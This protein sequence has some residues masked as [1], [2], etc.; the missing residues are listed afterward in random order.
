MSG[1]GRLHGLREDLREGVGSYLRRALAWRWRL[2]DPAR[3]WLLAALC[4]SLLPHLGRL[5]WLL[6]LPAMLLLA[7]RLAFELRL[8]RLPTRGLRW[9]LVGLALAATLGSYQTVLGRQAGVALLVIM[10][11]L[12]LMEMQ[13]PRD[14]AV[15]IGLNYFVVITVFL[16]DQSLLM[17]AYMLLVVILITTALVALSR[18]GSERPP[19]ADLRYALVLLAQAAPLA[20]LLFVL[21]PRIDGP[22]WHLPE[23]AAGASTGL[24]DSMSPGNISRLG[25]DDAVAFRVQFDGPLPPPGQRYWRALALTHFD[26][27]RWSNPDSAPHQRPPARNLDLQVNGTAVDYTLTLEPH[28]RRWLF[29]LDMPVS[30]PRQSSLSPDFELLAREPVASVQQYRLRS[31]PDYRLQ[32]QQ[33]PDAA[34]YGQLPAAAA[35][36][37]RLLAARLWA[38]SADAADYVQRV[39]AL[40]RQ[41]PFYYTRRP[42]H[43][44]DDPVDGFLF[45]TR[46]GYCEHY[47]SAFSVL[48]RAAGVPA[49]VMTGYLG[50]ETNPLGD[51][52][53]V[54]QSDAHAWVEVWLQGRGWV[55]VD[56]TAVIPPARVEVDARGA[57]GLRIPGLDALAGSGWAQAVWRRAGFAWDNL[58]HYWNQWVVGYD[59]DSQATL[60][61]ALGLG[62]LDAQGLAAVLFTAL[63]GVLGVLAWRVFR[64]GGLRRDP[65]ALAYARFCA[66]LGR[67]GLARGPAEGAEQF[68]RRLRAARPDLAPQVILVTRLYQHLRYARHPPRDGLQRLQAAVRR[69][70]P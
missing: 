3:L 9:L 38:E 18:P 2:V 32:A 46:R 70:H 6:I 1:A 53:M 14:V 36:R 35:P 24:S 49:R 16:F 29:A 41:Q 67:R 19:W 28:Q 42:P 54:R 40:F 48:M 22:L 20:L 51:Y 37:A 8:A 11:C 23:E 56:P 34:R 50:G 58:N 62:D 44:A 15:V 65:V 27:R 45:D 69:F 17:G 10:L 4:L 43:L 25:D 60:L 12:K 5:P 57:D 68:S 30:L 52:F 66:K 7:W 26:G 13:R 59:R 21:F 63:G 64:R 55:R 61:Q 31:F 33:A 39:L 47:A